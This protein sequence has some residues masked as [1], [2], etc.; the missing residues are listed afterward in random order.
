MR[1]VNADEIMGDILD[2]EIEITGEGSKFAREAVESY[3]AVVLRRI[4]AQPTE[5]VIFAN[6]IVDLIFGEDN[7]DAEAIVEVLCRKLNKL[8]VV[9]LD[10]DNW[11][12]VGE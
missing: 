3:R 5:K 11:K 8:G 4:M 12:A 10:G 1:V 2:G 9:E 6:E 7:R